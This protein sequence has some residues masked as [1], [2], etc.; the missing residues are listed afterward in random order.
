M[1]DRQHKESIVMNPAD[2]RIPADRYQRFV[3]Q[4][5]GELTPRERRAIQLRFWE[6]VTI[7]TVASRMGLSWDEADRLIDYAVAKMRRYFVSKLES[8]RRSI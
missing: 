6:T 1:S 8:E 2:I 5:L 7:A 4:A 3:E